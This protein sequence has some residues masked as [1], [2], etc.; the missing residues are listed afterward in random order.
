MDIVAKNQFGSGKSRHFGAGPKPC[1]SG[2]TSFVLHAFGVN[3]SPTS[4]RIEGLIDPMII[5]KPT[6][7]N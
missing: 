6:L 1:L 5:F 4:E 7:P 2:G 3:L